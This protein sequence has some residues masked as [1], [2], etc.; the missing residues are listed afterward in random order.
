MTFSQAVASCF[1]KYATFSGRARRAEYWWWCLFQSIGWAGAGI[2][3][4]LIF[5]IEGGNLIHALETPIE[6]IFLMAT[7]LPGLAVS[8]R[9]L[10]DINRSGWWLLIAFTGIGLL[11]LL[12]WAVLPSKDEG[13]RFSDIE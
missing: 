7:C 13:N 4:A 10:H 2:A 5:D 12:Y 6:T 8:V 3:D 1:S 9:R 11:L